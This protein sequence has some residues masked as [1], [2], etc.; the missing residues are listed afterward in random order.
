M[1]D[2]K[3]NDILKICNGQLLSGEIDT[4]IIDFSNDTRK[5]KKDDFYIAIKGEAINGNKFID[6]ALEKG[7]IGCIIDEDVD[8]AIIEKYKNRVIIKVEDT[9]KAIQE[10]AKYKRSLYNIPVIAVTGSVR[11]N[12]HKRCYCKCS[13]TKIYSFEDR[14]K[15]K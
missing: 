15:F 12:E 8:T 14:R 4:R 1:K 3:V 11:E 10:I 9:I 2:L 6:Q 7:A 13:I 5:I